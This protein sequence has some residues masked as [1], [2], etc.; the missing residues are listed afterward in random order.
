MWYACPPHGTHA[1]LALESHV[2][3]T[4]AT[5]RGDWGFGVVLLC[6]EWGPGDAGAVGI[7]RSTK[8]LVYGVFESLS[9][10]VVSQRWVKV[11]C[12]PLPTYWLLASVRGSAS[13]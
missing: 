3:R 6:V 4:C 10:S 11:K 2:G 1:V 13:V 9:S 8:V 7:S 12:V 5:H